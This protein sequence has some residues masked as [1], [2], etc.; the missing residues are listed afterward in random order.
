MSGLI[1][2]DEVNKEIRLDILLNNKLSIERKIVDYKNNIRCL[3]DELLSLTKEI[4]LTCDHE[5]CRDHSASYGDLC[6]KYCK[7]CLLYNNKNFY[8]K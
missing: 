4:W 3:Q 8:L 1:K 5:W 2:K 6:N 7:K